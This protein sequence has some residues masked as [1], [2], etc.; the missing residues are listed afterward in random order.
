MRLI[1]EEDSVT[2]QI[3][4]SSARLAASSLSKGPRSALFQEKSEYPQNIEPGAD[5]IVSGRYIVNRRRSFAVASAP[6]APSSL[7][8]TNC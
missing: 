8:R 4:L 7:G 5:E 2:K 6:S 3:W 1:N